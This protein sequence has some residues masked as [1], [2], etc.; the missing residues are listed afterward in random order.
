MYITKIIECATNQNKR[1]T[2]KR[3]K[4]ESREGSRGKILE[5]ILAIFNEKFALLTSS[6]I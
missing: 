1:K 2:T 3:R 6:S 5:Q 4:V